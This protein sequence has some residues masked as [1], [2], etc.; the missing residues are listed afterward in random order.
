VI[1]ERE[2]ERYRVKPGSDVALRCHE[3]RAGG[4]GGEKEDAEKETAA[5]RRRLAELVETLY[6]D[7]RYAVLVVIQAMDAA[8]KDSTVRRC[9]GSLN[10]MRC[11]TAQFKTPT[12]EESAHDFL[13][14]VHNHVPPRGMVGIFNRSH[15]EDVLAVRV[16]GLAA[17]DTID[18][19]YGHINAFEKMLYDE[20]T[21]IVKVYLHV[22]KE[23]QRRRL[24][25]RLKRPDKRWKFSV[26]DL[27][28]R[29]LWD[30]YTRAY[31]QALARCSTAEA[32][33][34][35]VPSERRWYRDL[36]ICSIVVR[37]LESLDLRYPSIEMDPDKIVVE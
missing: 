2:V 14:R 8:G 24:V 27:E 36:L 35:I 19:R 12:E 22:S 13:W 32:P 26:S 34:Y 6:V 9:F 1:E 7:G 29:R 16:K 11:T 5:L 25:R 33:W 10:P 23:Y 28:E 4:G 31:Q 3:S 30:D 37:L 18:R 20:G 21:R 15:Y 17:R